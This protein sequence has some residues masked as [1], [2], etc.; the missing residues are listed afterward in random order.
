VESQ[1]EYQQISAN[2]A[3]RG[4]RR[5]DRDPMHGRGDGGACGGRGGGRNFNNNGGCSKIPCQV[6]DK[7]G[8][9]ILHSVAIKDLLQVIMAKRNKPM[10]RL[11]DIMWTQSWIQVPLITL[12]RSWIN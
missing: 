9:A 1:K 8:Q 5:G 6:C 2:V 3:L 12:L 7:T 4:G 10:Q 11:Q